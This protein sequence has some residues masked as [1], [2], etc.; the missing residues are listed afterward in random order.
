MC[1]NFWWGL[2]QGLTY[3]NLVSTENFYREFALQ[4]QNI[5]RMYSF[6]VLCLTGKSISWN[7]NKLNI[8][9]FLARLPEEIR[10]MS[11]HCPSASV[12]TGECLENCSQ[13]YCRSQVFNNAKFSTRLVKVILNWH[14]PL[15]GQLQ[16]KFSGSLFHLGVGWSGNECTFPRDLQCT[17][18]T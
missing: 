7:E 5:E 1:V 8:S 12:P 16:Y 4:Q 9:L 11:L 3:N 15:T 17:A 13:I 6:I 2:L 10:L 14:F 18:G